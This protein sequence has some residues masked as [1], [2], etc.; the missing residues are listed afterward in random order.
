MWSKRHC[1]NTLSWEMFNGQIVVLFNELLKYMINHLSMLCMHDCKLSLQPIAS[2]T[3]KNRFFL[4]SYIIKHP[5]LDKRNVLFNKLHLP[6]QRRDQNQMQREGMG[7]RSCF[8][9][10]HNAQLICFSF[11]FLSVTVSV[12][13]FGAVVFECYDNWIFVLLWQREFYVK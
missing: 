2:F 10:T 4:F 11:L 6:L 7:H 12:S 3:I 8:R 5:H 13:A 9:L 1:S